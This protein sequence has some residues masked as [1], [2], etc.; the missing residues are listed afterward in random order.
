MIRRNK[1]F[2]RN[3]II[4]LF[5]LFL[6]LTI[7]YR[8]FNSK[9][10]E[11]L[12]DYQS[13]VLKWVNCYG[14]F[15]CSTLL[16]PVAYDKITTDAFHLKVIRFKATDQRQKLGALTVNPGG[17]GASAFDYASSY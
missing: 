8:S 12:K 17:P 10:F 16:V 6:T 4:T 7:F 3:T 13:Q 9:T 11:N 15:E 2:F 5:I 14:N 1:S